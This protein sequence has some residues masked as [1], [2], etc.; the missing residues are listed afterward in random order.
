MKKRPTTV[1]AERPQPP[2]WR[3]RGA[4]P[5]G[6]STGSTGSAAGSGAPRARR[7]ARP[8]RRGAAAASAAP[9]TSWYSASSGGSRPAAAG[10]ASCSPNEIRDS[11]GGSRGA[12]A[13]PV[14]VALHAAEPGDDRGPG[15]GHRRDVHAV[16]GVA[17]Q[18]VEVDERGLGEVVVGQVE[19]PG[20]R[21]HHRLGARR[22]R[23]V[24]HRDRLVVGEVA[25]HL[26]GR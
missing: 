24:P 13:Q 22:Q 3:A 16:V 2:G 4:R 10:R 7:P 9:P 26:L 19:V 17:R 21:R 8:A 6:C 11:A 23:R 12:N 1:P 18:V 20:P 14:G 15:A 25:R 5:Y